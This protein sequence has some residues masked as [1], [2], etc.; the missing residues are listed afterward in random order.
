MEERYSFGLGDDQDLVEEGKK[1]A[2][3]LSTYALV[4]HL[5]R[6]HHF[7]VTSIMN[8][9]Y[10]HLQLFPST[11]LAQET[12]CQKKRGAANFVDCF[13]FARGIQD[14]RSKPIKALDVVERGVLPV[15][16]LAR[17]RPR[18]RSWWYFP[19]DR[20]TGRGGSRDPMIVEW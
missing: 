18:T 6:L 10:S 4:I 11:N 1:L 17:R 12:Q 16:A 9:K 8:H 7:L 15:P 14:N 2:N 20:S 5:P 13:C 3:V 19:T